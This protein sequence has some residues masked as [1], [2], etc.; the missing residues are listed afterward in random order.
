M[1]PEALEVRGTLRYFWWVNGYDSSD[2]SL[3]GAEEDLRAAVAA[4][5]SLA[6]AWAR[7]SSLLRFTGRFAEAQ[8]AASRALEADAF[9]LEA[10][11]VYATLYYAALNLEHYGDATNWCNRARARFPTDLEFGHCE[12]RTLGWSGRG[13]AARAR[14]WRI[15]DSLDGT[16]QAHTSTY[17][18]ERR[19][20]LA[21]LYARSS[22]PDSAQ[23]LLAV[24]R[25]NAGQDSIAGWFL[26]AESY[27]RLLLGER[28]AALRLLTRALAVNPQ[29]R[30]Y[31]SRA[32]WFAPLRREPEFLR[33]VTP[34]S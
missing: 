8:E 25:S 28:Q 29:L 16:P 18:S 34:P 14:A 30:N 31:V 22:D 10:R 15:V 23:A 32:A 11:P 1:T 20:L 19:L 26:F 21:M 13:H 2:V 6:R 33:I 9:L 17:P 7:L 24:S 27:V 4:E 5:P 12:L 3:L